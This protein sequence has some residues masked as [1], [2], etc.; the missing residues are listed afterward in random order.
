[1]RVFWW[2]TRARNESECRTE[3]QAAGSPDAESFS[4]RL[5]TSI[6]V[7]TRKMVNF[8]GIG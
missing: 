6:S 7:G 8:A 1:M 2:Q 4:M 3:A 5:R